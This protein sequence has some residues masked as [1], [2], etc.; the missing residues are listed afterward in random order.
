MSKIGKRNYQTFDIYK[1]KKLMDLGVECNI[2]G[3][4]RYFHNPKGRIIIM[5]IYDPHSMG[6]GIGF[7]VHTSNPKNKMLT[8]MCFVEDRHWD[9]MQEPNHG[10][11]YN[12]DLEDYESIARFIS[13]TC[14]LPDMILKS[15]YKEKS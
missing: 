10:L 12:S 2:S 3:M 8:D 11:G 13:K 7:T 9:N 5:Q 15:K 14:S 1:L 6:G 4:E